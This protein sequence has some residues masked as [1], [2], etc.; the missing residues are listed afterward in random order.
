MP[1]QKP[2]QQH[3]ENATPT[4]AR[5]GRGGAR[6]GAGRKPKY[7]AKLQTAQVQM[8]PE[9]WE[10]LDAQRGGKARGEYL[11]LL[12]GIDLPG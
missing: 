8:L 9:A 7:G 2:A 1:T 4:P 5:Q 6:K 12:L 11:M 10:Q 3:G